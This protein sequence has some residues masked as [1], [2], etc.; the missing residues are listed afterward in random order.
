MLVQLWL[1]LAALV[2]TTLTVLT[3]C[4]EQ[5]HSCVRSS[6]VLARRRRPA[7]RARV[8][9]DFL[10]RQQPAVGLASSRAGKL[11]AGGC[12]LHCLPGIT[13][14]SHA[15]PAAGQETHSWWRIPTSACPPPPLQVGP[16][17]P[18]EVAVP[19]IHADHLNVASTGKERDVFS[20]AKDSHNEFRPPISCDLSP[21]CIRTPH[22]F[23]SH[24]FCVFLP[25]PALISSAMKCYK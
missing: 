14:G 3:A 4:S 19:E 6:N 24:S 12:R 11:A 7:D 16:R 2:A 17:G 13:L 1:R 8:H 25:L 22:F 15:N 23:F 9:A 5:R 21:T 18:P 10:R 20:G